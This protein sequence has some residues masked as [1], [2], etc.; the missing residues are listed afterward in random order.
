M[1]RAG[2]LH[3]GAWIPWSR[4]ALDLGALRAILRVGLP[5]ALHFAAEIWG[6][7]IAGLWAGQLGKV[8]FAAN[9]IVL[10][11]AS[12]SFMLP[13]GIALAAVTRVGNLMGEGRPRD[14]QTSASTA[15]MLGAGVMSL[16]ALAFLV[17]RD[18]LPRCYSDDEAVLALAALT[19][20]VA[21]AFQL[22]DGVQVVASGIL[23]A[24]GT[25]LPTA[26]A[27]FAGYYVIGL[28]IGWWLTFRLGY[29][30]PGLWWGVAIGIAVVAVLLVIWIAVRGPAKHVALV[31]AAREPAA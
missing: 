17:F 30:V 31:R 19:L 9:V 18:V 14:A 11:L 12:I 1:I 8:E 29:G 5:Q 6:F 10:N 2:R 27:N 3:E 28:P 20:P 13:L 26:I 22:F 16:C 4:A 24:V 15:L 21:A 23:R 25:T 7:Q